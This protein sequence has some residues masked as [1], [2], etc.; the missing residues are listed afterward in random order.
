MTPADLTTWRET[1]A[2]TKVELARLLGVQ[3]LAVS[4]WEGGTR[5]IPPFLPLA[6]AELRRQFMA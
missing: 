5:S 6:L 3:P 1:H 4:R 2:L